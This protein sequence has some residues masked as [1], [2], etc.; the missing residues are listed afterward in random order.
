MFKAHKSNVHKCPDCPQELATALGVEL[1]RHRVHG[2]PK[3]SKLRETVTM[4]HFKTENKDQWRSDTSLYNKNVPRLMTDK[5]ASKMYMKSR[6]LTQ[7]SL[8]SAHRYVAFM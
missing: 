5:I 6:Q 1:H 4:Q 8:N 7:S 2:M 3:P